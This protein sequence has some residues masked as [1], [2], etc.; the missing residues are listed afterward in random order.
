MNDV[1]EQERKKAAF[2]S[3]YK[4]ICERYGMILIQVMHDVEYCPQAVAT[5]DLCPHAPARQVEQ[6]LIEH[7][8]TIEWS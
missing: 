5:T 3:E 4:A 6:A 7:I 8:R 1:D 2:L